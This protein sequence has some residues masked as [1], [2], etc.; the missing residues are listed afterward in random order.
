M[1][2]AIIVTPSTLVG[3]WVKEIAKWVPAIKP[4]YLSVT[5]RKP[6]PGEVITGTMQDCL[7]RFEHAQISPVLIVSYEQF[8]S[9][10]DEILAL[11]CDLIICDEVLNGTSE[12]LTLNFRATESR[13]PHRK[14]EQR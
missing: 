2:K 5:A 13:M 9:N 8:R 12:F 1:Q 11:R 10:S 7:M 6:K 14:S 3:N 4:L